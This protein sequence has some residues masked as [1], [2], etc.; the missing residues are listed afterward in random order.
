MKLYHRYDTT[1]E[2]AFLTFWSFIH[3]L[4]GIMLFTVIARLIRNTSFGIWTIFGIASL[5][6]L[7]YELKDIRGSYMTKPT[8]YN[9][10]QNSI[11]DQ[12]C[13]SL[14]MLIAF[15][16]LGTSC[17]D[18]DVLYTALIYTSVFLLTEIT[19]YEKANPRE[20]VYGEYIV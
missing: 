10:W 19:G 16:A 3:F 13:A 15:T 18:S 20:V 14:G 17:T 2:P 1:D 6:H 5:I 9:S 12:L 11:G 7:L 8:S 4:C